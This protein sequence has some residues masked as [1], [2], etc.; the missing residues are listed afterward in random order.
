MSSALS[1][2]MQYMFTGINTV[3]ASTIGLPVILPRN[4]YL[5]P[6]ETALAE[7]VFLVLPLFLMYVL[8]M[9]V[10][11]MMLYPLRLLRRAHEHTP[12]VVADL[13][14]RLR[15]SAAHFW[16]KQPT[17]KHMDKMMDWLL[18]PP[19]PHSWWFHQVRGAVQLP[20]AFT[21][22][23][24]GMLL[25]KTNACSSVWCGW[26]CAQV[27]AA[28]V[29]STTA[30]QFDRRHR[31]AAAG[32]RAHRVVEVDLPEDGIYNAHFNFKKLAA[33]FDTYFLDFPSRCGPTRTFLARAAKEEELRT[34]SRCLVHSCTQR[35]QGGRGS[36]RAG[37]GDGGRARGAAKVV[38]AQRRAQ[39]ARVP[40]RHAQPPAAA[41]ALPRHGH[42]RCTL[43]L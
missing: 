13:R 3:S 22:L 24:R 39:R 14:D 26:P 38:R 29:R 7:I 8:W 33:E 34:N 21:L 4:V 32:S 23:A 6:A 43:G 5:H 35:S 12:G 40:Q 30:A 18:L 36:P 37:P 25:R 10:A 20:C 1:T 31:R 19:M 15:W 11:A 27:Y 17:N 28:V 9:F 41:A 42:R 16:A 2:L